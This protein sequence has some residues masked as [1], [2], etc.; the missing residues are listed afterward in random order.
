MDIKTIERENENNM[1]IDIDLFLN[2]FLI[3]STKKIWS[4]VSNMHVII[5]VQYWRD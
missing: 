3:R 1:S 4:F 5:T 2:G